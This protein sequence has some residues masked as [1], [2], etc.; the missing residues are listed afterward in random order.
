MTD[1]PYHDL[2]RL[3]RKIQLCQKSVDKMTL[4]F[5]YNVFRCRYV[6][7]HIQ[8]TGVAIE[9]QGFTV[10]TSGKKRESLL[11]SFYLTQF[12]ILWKDFKSNAYGCLRIIGKFF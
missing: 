12:S 8:R 6:E 1:T 7:E 2:E 9:T 3:Y 10:V 5:F 4:I 11:V